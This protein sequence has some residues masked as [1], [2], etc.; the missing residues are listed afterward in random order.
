VVVVLVM[1]VVVFVVVVFICHRILYV[2]CP[3]RPLGAWRAMKLCGVK[4]EGGVEKGLKLGVK[5][6]ANEINERS[7][8]SENWLAESY[9]VD[10]K[11]HSHFFVF[12]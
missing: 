11:L 12:Y 8:G 9:R 10:C 1:V 5:E 6:R 3:A 7:E 2:M 4:N